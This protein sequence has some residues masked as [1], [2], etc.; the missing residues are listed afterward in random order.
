[1]KRKK[2]FHHMEVRVNSDVLIIEL[3][4][5]SETVRKDRNSV[6]GT[7]YLAVVQFPERW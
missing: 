4:G 1:M 3:S 5:L 2:L 7:P 6:C